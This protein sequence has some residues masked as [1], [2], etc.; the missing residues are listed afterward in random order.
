MFFTG[1]LMRFFFEKP[2]IFGEKL[3]VKTEIDNAGSATDHSSERNFIASNWKK[4]YDIQGVRF[5]P[6]FFKT[7][8]T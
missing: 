1:N 8:Y 3:P 4:S 7:G 2:I 6:S 5:F